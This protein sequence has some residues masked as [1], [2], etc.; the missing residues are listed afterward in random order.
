MSKAIL[1]IV[2][3]NYLF[4]GR[5]RRHIE[6]LARY[7]DVVVINLGA[8]NVQKETKIISKEK[9]IITLV[10]SN[11]IF[12]NLIFK[13]LALFFTSLVYILKNKPDVVVSLN[14]F[15]IYIVLTKFFLSK[16]IYIYDAYELLITDSNSIKRDK[17]WF[18]IEKMFIKGYDIVIAAN[19]ERA[20]L[21]KDYYGKYFFKRLLEIRNIP[22]FSQG[23]IESVEVIIGDWNSKILKSDKVVLY[24]G[25]VTEDRN[26][27]KFIASL[28]SL[29]VNYKILIVGDG[30]ALPNLKTRF[31]D[32]EDQNRL[33]F[34]GRVENNKLFHFT[35]LGKVG[36]VSYP[37]TGLNNIYCSPNK[38]YE[39]TQF[40]LALLCTQQPP[41]ENVIDKY[42][43]GKCISKDDSSEM[44]AKK[45]EEIFNSLETYQ[46]N[47][48]TFAKENTWE[49]E[50]REYRL[51]LENIT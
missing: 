45:I 2:Y 38:I 13:H 50:V 28:Y 8:N 24:Q 47:I 10:N 23:L 27:G 17:F 51:I 48:Q 31:K 5:A 41:L 15:T 29:P 7:R 12:N 35:G 36:I 44:V 18:R 1:C 33:V 20:S 32:L 30:A 37:Y 49:K 19:E 22:Q 3:G 26:L 16:S 4:D 9:N 21:M 14:Y 11:S 42:G 39:Y 6:E 40:G 43:I 25:D 46:Q 34:T